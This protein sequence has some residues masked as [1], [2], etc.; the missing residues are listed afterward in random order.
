MQIKKIL[1][2]S[3]IALSTLGGCTEDFLTV[4]PNDQLSEAT[5]WRNQGD[6]EMALASCYHRFESY[7]NIAFMDTGTDNGYD[8]FNFWYK[9][10]ANAG[11][12]ASTN[13][14]TIKGNWVCWHSHIWSLYKKIRVYNTFLEKV[15]EVEMD[16]KM[17]KQYI[18]EV[19]F[20]RAYDYFW[21][22]SLFGDMPLVT[23]VLATDEVNTPRTPKAEIEA[24]ILSELA[25]VAPDL[26]EYNTIDSKGHITRG[27]AY[28]LK[29]RLEL[30]M[31]RYEDAQ[32]SAKKVIDMNCFELYP[33]Y[34]EMFYETSEG[35]N[36]EYILSVKH[37]AVNHPQ[38]LTQ[39]LPPP[40]GGG[41]SS[42]EPTYDF[43]MAYQT[44]DGKYIDDP[45]SGFDEDKP[46]ENRDPRLGYT[47]L[48]PGCTYR[49]KI[50]N[51]LD[52]VVDGEPNIDH[53]Q[54]SKKNSCVGGMTMIK[55]VH[56]VDP[57]MVNNYD[58]DLV[59]IRLAEM[60]ITFAECALKT[61][62]DKALA[63]QY[64][65]AIRARSNMPA[66][67]VLDER[68]VKY[69]RRIELAF[70][71]LRYFDIKRWDMGK[72]VFD[73]KQIYGLR[74]GTID[75]DGNVT[76]KGDKNDKPTAKTEGSFY[77]YELRKFVPERKYLA[78]IPQTELDRNPEMTQNEG[79]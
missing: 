31:G 73:Q 28:A 51:P 35:S 65:N 34:E 38:R 63:L 8:K 15:P 39:M 56:E 5:F 40:S 72:E 11:L 75:A 9:R 52:A 45:T 20:L 25:A 1:G 14:S 43:M 55:F 50:F 48:Y 26:P 10:L 21:K 62:K 24:F 37:D 30:Y 33:D 36:K 58:A 54:T 60:Y 49:G 79:Y 68:L 6:V 74:R 17:K 78:P 44:A 66:A 67:S 70:E 53:F 47:M 59:V 77:K 57:S 61:G 7:M 16:E 29:A 27:A 18:A 42:I 22:V 12:S 46:F 41:Y 23:K 4:T 13:P 76:W 64:I 3:L 2:I 69:E 32:A 19:R 71:G